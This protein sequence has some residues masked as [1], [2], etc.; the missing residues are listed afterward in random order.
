MGAVLFRHADWS[1]SLPLLQIEAGN[2]LNALGS[3]RPNSAADLLSEVSMSS[4]KG[5]QLVILG[6]VRPYAAL[7]E[8][9]SRFE[10]R[11]WQ[12]AL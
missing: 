3:V 9:F 4:Q 12:A 6:P 8:S 2:C 5:K 7:C 10:L 1:K 11:Q